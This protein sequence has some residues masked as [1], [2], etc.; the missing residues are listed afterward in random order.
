[1]EEGQEDTQEELLRASHTTITEKCIKATR[2]TTANQNPVPTIKGVQK[3]KS[4]DIRICCNTPEEAEALKQVDWNIAYQGLKI[5][6]PKFGIVIHG[7]PTTM[8]DAANIYSEDI[9][10]LEMQ[11]A[12]KQIKV[13]KIVPLRRNKPIDDPA[14]HNSVV[15]FLDSPIAA[16]ACI[17]EGVFIDHCFFGAVE[18]YAPQLRRTQCY[19][20]QRFGHI[21]S[22]CRA[23]H[24]TCGK[25]SGQHATQA[26]TESNFKCA[27]CQGA[28]PAWDKECPQRA[29]EESRL[30]NTRRNTSPYHTECQK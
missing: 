9:Q 10:R 4:G 8:L 25:C 15:V 3:L 13:S 29:Q 27:A 1:M 28:H 7:V 11:N 2:K 26:C 22:Q 21:A 24:S 5:R 17:K 30:A 6:K 19:N 23:S 20:C 18:K 14:M 16:D 12:S